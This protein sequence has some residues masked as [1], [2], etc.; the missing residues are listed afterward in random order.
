MFVGGLHLSS[1]PQGQTQFHVPVNQYIY[2]L[3]HDYLKY[4]LNSKLRLVLKKNVC[5]LQCLKN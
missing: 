5:L 3:L 2:E 4:H 1:R